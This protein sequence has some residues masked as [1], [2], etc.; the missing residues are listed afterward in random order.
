MSLPILMRNLSIGLTDSNLT[1]NPVVTVSL[2]SNWTNP[3]HF[4]RL[5]QRK[6]SVGSA[7]SGADTTME[8]ETPKKSKKKKKKLDGENGDANGT[9]TNGDAAEE[10]EQPKKE[11]KKKKKKDKQEEDE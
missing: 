8:T 6:L 3:L 4:L 11:K 10:E 1:D 5:L 9:E 2:K 7:A